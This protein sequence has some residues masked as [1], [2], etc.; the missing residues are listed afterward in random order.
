M[1]RLSVW[2]AVAIV[3]AGGATAMA[4]G[5]TLRAVMQ[6]LGSDMHAL[7]QAILVSDY[8]AAARAAGAIADH[9]HVGAGEQ[10]RIGKIL[11]PDMKTFK[12]LDMRVHDTAV[13]LRDAARGQ[14]TGAVARRFGEL[15]RGCTQC[16]S[17][18][19]D[20]LRTGAR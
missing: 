19:R 15:L 18:M 20:R 2:A 16:H 8:E 11:G 17:S 7:V 6:Q 3:A 4:E 10:A 14:D 13:A 9:P 1:K 12:A 5:P